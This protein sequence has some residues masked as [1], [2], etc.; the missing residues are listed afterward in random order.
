MLNGVVDRNRSFPV[1]I[2]VRYFWY[3]FDMGLSL[4]TCNRG[5]SV[6]IC[7]FILLLRKTV[8]SVPRTDS[9]L[10]RYSELLVGNLGAPLEL[11]CGILDNEEEEEVIHITANPSLGISYGAES[12]QEPSATAHTARMS[13]SLDETDVSKQHS[14]FL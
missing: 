11:G 3:N 13:L 6:C 1:A 14:R 5:L 12:L 9:Y 10:R 7:R 4:T 8:V 2:T